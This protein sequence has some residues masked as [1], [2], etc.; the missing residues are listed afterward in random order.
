MKGAMVDDSY[1]LKIDVK[2]DAGGMITGGLVIG[3]ITFQ[4]QEFI[5]MAKK[6]EFK[7]APLRGV[8]INYFLDDENPENLVRAIRTELAA[9]GIAELIV[10]FMWGSE[11][12][13]VKLAQKVLGVE[14]DGVVGVKTL[15]VINSQ[16][17][18]E[19]W[20]NLKKKHENN[21]FVN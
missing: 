21:F 12:V 6:G 13:G 20:D 5:I 7:E 15:A 8:G 10:Q 4:N 17:P 18:S 11:T 1:D 19:L 16:N 9:E 2:R 14:Q 3:D